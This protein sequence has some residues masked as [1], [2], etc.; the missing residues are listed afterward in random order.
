MGIVGYKLSVKAYSYLVLNPH[1]YN[2]TATSTQLRLPIC[3]DA[4][5][6]LSIIIRK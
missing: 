1:P 6:G 4:N 2:T 3:T 5:E